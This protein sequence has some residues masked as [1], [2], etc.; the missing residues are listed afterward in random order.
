MNMKICCVTGHRDIPKEQK[1]YVRESLRREILAAIADGFTGFMS[2]FAEGVDQDFAEIVIEL[3]QTYPDLQLMAAI[4]TRQRLNSL[5]KKPETK[6]MLDCCSDI[7]VI[8]EDYHPSVYSHRNRYM[9]EKSGRVIAVYDGREKG[10]TVG[11]IRFTHTL[12]KE[13]REIPVGAEIIDPQK[14][15]TE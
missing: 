13:L 7:T 1:S 11:T 2:G 8:R 4:P 5:E 12:K 14:L 3:K 6:A 10:G 9:V 15:L